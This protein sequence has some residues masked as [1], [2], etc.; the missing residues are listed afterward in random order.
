MS[1]LPPLSLSVCV[2]GGGVCGQ[3]HATAH[4]WK[5]KGNFVEL[6]LSFTLVPVMELSLALASVSG[7]RSPIGSTKACSYTTSLH[8]I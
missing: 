6:V 1:L 2:C 3:V 8:Y 5:F 7:P 4:R